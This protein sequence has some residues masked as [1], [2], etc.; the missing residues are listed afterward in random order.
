MPIDHADPF[1]SA[2][3]AQAA[4]GDDPAVPRNH[5]YW[6][7]D[8]N[9]G[10]ANLIVTDDKPRKGGWQRVTTMVKAIGDAYMLDQWHQRLLIQGLVQRPDLYDLA[11]ATLA[12]TDPDDPKALREDLQVIAHRV[13]A[14]VGADEGA[15]LG[16]AFHGFTEAQDL[17][18]M[19]YARRRWHGKLRS[20]S[21]GLKAQR[22]EVIPEYIERRIVVLKYGIAGTLDRI[23]LD[24]VDGVLRI[25]DL[26]SVKQFWTWLEIGAQLAA[27]SLADA[28]WDRKR[29]EYI[30]MPP[31]AQD[32]GIV[33]WMPVEHPDS[34]GG[35]GVDFFD[36]DLERGREALEVAARAVKLRSEASSAKQTWGVLRPAPA[37]KPVEAYAR[38]LA[39]VETP[40]EGSAVWAE[41]VKVGLADVPELVTLA[42]EVAQKLVAITTEA[43]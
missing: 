3:Q 25:G 29:H 13:L 24:Q 14:A 20:Y 28:M 37:M 7:P 36:V 19:H 40:G 17:G 6:L 30:D 43:V 2:S 16:T 31:V 32:F 42:E 33:A 15:N 4:R 8:L 10:P 34:A 22:L 26:K 27:Y 12:T 35:D 18:L 38:R 41:V 1:M 23:L 11:C 5:R 39:E 9:I 21:E